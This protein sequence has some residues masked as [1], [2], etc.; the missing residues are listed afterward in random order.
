MARP[1]RI[2][3]KRTSRSLTC[4]QRP[5]CFMMRAIGMRP[6]A[7]LMHLATQLSAEAEL[8][9]LADLMLD[10]GEPNFAL[11]LA[12]IAVQQGIVLPRA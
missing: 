6:A 1:T 5:S 3:K 12:K 7:S 11:K 9:A 2:G 8:G 4:W 10:W